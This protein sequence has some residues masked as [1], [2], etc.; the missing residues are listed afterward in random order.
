[1][2]FTVNHFL[3]RLDGN[4]S[5]FIINAQLHSGLEVDVR[6]IINLREFKRDLKLF[7]INL[8][9]VRESS[10]G[11]GIGCWFGVDDIVRFIDYNRHTNFSTG[12][13]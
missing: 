13:S 10:G 1:M 5:G 9:V 8:G 3:P 6:S 11:I 12:P 7:L 2:L 4:L